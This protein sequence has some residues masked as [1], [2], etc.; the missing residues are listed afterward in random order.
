MTPPDGT[1][2]EARAICDCLECRYP[3]EPK[4]LGRCKA[5][6]IATA[7]RARTAERDAGDALA[8]ARA[9]AAMWKGERDRLAAE[10]VSD[11]V[12]E[13]VCEQRDRLAERLRQAI[14]SR[15]G[16]MAQ[17]EREGEIVRA[18]TERLRVLQAGAR[19]ETP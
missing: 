1:E 17:A 8:V 18:M 19:G 2:A 4:Q 15:D 7:L 6:R 3:E 11:T 14:E 10:R 13:T 16:W 5:D 12:Y 9:H